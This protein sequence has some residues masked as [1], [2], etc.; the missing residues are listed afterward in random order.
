MGFFYKT[1]SFNSV[2]QLLTDVAIFL[3]FIHIFSTRSLK[4]KTLWEGR[5]LLGTWS[6]L[7]HFVSLIVFF[8]GNY[9]FY[10]LAVF[11]LSLMCCIRRIWSVIFEDL[12]SHF[13]EPFTLK[14]KPVIAMSKTAFLI[15][16]FSSFY[17]SWTCRTFKFQHCKPFIFTYI[18]ILQD[19]IRA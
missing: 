6:N 12:M 18:F 16:E 1:L 13:L 17:E 5:G 19:D 7:L 3:C 15:L 11:L 10:L 2:L 8:E 14:H 9:N 4:T